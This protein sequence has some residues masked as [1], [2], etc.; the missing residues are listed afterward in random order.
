VRRGEIAY[1]WRVPRRVR[2]LFT[3]GYEG[4]SPAELIAA[5][6]RAR[7]TR[8]LDIRQLPLSRRKGFSKTPLRL[9]LEAAGIEYVHVR[10][11]GNPDRHAPG[12]PMAALAAYRDRLETSPQIL[13]EVLG[14]I[15]SH[16]AALLCV[17][18]T[19]AVCHRSVL[20]ERLT[21]HFAIRVT[22]L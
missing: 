3:I 21:E 11:A 7:V 19:H 1:A 20:S 13:D 22:H 12:G 16:R 10:A 5:L 2:P 4:R 17:E 8:L 18:A 6:R 9:A 15:G 14:E